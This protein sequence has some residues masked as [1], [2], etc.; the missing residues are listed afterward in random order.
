MQLVNFPACDVQSGSGRGALSTWA[1]RSGA[2]L[3]GVDPAT[4][5]MGSFDFWPMPA[6]AACAKTSS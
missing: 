4:V 1:F 5:D 6:P 2:V 3:P